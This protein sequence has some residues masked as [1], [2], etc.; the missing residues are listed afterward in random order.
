MSVSDEERRE[1]EKTGVLVSKKLMEI[2]D[3][4]ADI[5]ALL[6]ESHPTPFGSKNWQYAC[7]EAQQRVV[8][9]TAI[10][11]LLFEPVGLVKGNDDLKEVAEKMVGI[12]VAQLRTLKTKKSDW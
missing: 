1:A 3:S 4:Q 6:R 10:Q 2:M 8:A 7:I 12:L 5:D 9:M 11:F